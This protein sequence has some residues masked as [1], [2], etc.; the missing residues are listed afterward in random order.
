MPVPQSWPCELTNRSS[1]CQG[2]AA[3]S[4]HLAS[5]SGRATTVG[6]T[7]LLGA[8]ACRP[9]TGC[10]SQL[11]PGLWASLRPEEGASGG[12]Q[13]R[14]Q[15]AFA[16]ERLRIRDAQCCRNRRK[17]ASVLEERTVHQP[18]GPA[19]GKRSEWQRSGLRDIA[20]LFAP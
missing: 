3:T 10:G 12:R 7:A 17:L 2:V 13:R 6:T 20:M 15:C 1:A 8:E 16:G 11:G 18:R 5:T 9:G 4:I 14:Q 19:C